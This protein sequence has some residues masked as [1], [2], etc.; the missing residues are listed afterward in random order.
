MPSPPRLRLLAR[1][2]PLPPPPHHLRLPTRSLSQQPPVS[3]TLTPQPPRRRSLLLYFVQGTL[4]LHIFT[5]HFFALK[6]G[7]GPS[8]LPTAEVTGQWFLV[9]KHH[10]RGRG[11]HVG[12]L[13]IFDLPFHRDDMGMKRVLGLPG[14]YVLVD[15]PRTP[16]TATTS[17]ELM[18][19]VCVTRSTI[20]PLSSFQTTH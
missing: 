16:I 2:P 7:D 8:M 18:I 15:A 4:L 6:R 11:L 5:E 13:V 3:L 10:S 20:H 12:D 1:A 14:D 19:Q 9:S 17:D